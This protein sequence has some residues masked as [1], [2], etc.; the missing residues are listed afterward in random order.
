MGVPWYSMTL[1]HSNMLGLLNA[2]PNRLGEAGEYADLVVD[3][4]NNEMLNG[5]VV[6]IN[7]G[8]MLI[9]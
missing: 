1:R 2:F 7:A 6:D 3:V 8:A 4:Y 5:E 9:P